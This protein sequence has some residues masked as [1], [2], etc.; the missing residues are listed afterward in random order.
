M[1]IL[2]VTTIFNKAKENY[3]LMV[4]T[5]RRVVFLLCLWY[6]S[7]TI[8]RDLCWEPWQGI[9]ERAAKI[10]VY[11]IENLSQFFNNIAWLLITY[12][13]ASI[14]RWNLYL[15]KIETKR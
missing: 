1:L 3:K 11:V 2:S 7:D 4:H 12:N 6:S 5:C 10:K 15:F 13:T 8:S 14:E 9:A